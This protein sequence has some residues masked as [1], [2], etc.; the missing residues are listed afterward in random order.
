MTVP[1]PTPAQG[2]AV[3][4]PYPPALYAVIGLLRL[5]GDSGHGYDLARHLAPGEPLAEVIRLEPGMLYHYLKGLERL[6]WVTVD[7]QAQATRPSRHVYALTDTGRTAW[8]AWL[9]EPVG[10]TREIRFT[11]LLKWFFATT[12]D[13]TAASPLLAA[14]RATCARLVAS[15]TAQLA[16][17]EPG[18]PGTVDDPGASG[19]M[20]DPGDPGAG[21]DGG[22]GGRDRDHFRRAVL[23]LRLSQ[24][25]AVEGWLDRL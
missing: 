4:R 22:D 8:D 5:E 2:R 9:R 6:G 14:Q 16:A 21:P 24:T 1:S 10:Q 23:D 19:E 18:H 7:H 20:Q 25:R 3:A 13:P 15:L 17:A 12:T 11:F